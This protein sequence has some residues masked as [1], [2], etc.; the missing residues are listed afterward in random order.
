M[1]LHEQSMLHRQPK[2]IL[3]DLINVIEKVRLAC[4]P[5]PEKWE[6]AR[7][8]AMELCKETIHYVKYQTESREQALKLFFAIEQALNFCRNVKDL[9][10]RGQE[11]ADP[12][13]A[14]FY[15]RLAKFTGADYHRAAA[16]AAAR[17]IVCLSQF[18]AEINLVPSVAGCQIVKEMHHQGDVASTSNRFAASSSVNHSLS[19]IGEILLSLRES[20]NQNEW[21]VAEN[22]ANQLFQTVSQMKN[23]PENEGEAQAHK[24]DRWNEWFEWIQHLIDAIQKASTLFQTVNHSLVHEDENKR[25]HKNRLQ[26]QECVAMRLRYIVTYFRRGALADTRDRKSTEEISIKA[27]ALAMFYLEGLYGY[28]RLVQVEQRNQGDIFHVYDLTEAQKM[29]LNEQ[30]S[31]LTCFV[32]QAEELAQA[33]VTALNTPQQG[34]T[35]KSQSDKHCVKLFDLIL[36]HI[37]PNTKKLAKDIKDITNRIR[38]PSG[39]KTSP[40]QEAKIHVWAN[41][42]DLIEEIQSK[43]SRSLLGEV[44]RINECITSNPNHSSDPLSS[45]ALQI[46]DLIKNLSE[47][48]SKHLAPMVQEAMKKIE[49]ILQNNDTS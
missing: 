10:K 39:E 25:S 8:Y 29:K 28:I 34:D 17:V 33:L 27:K 6:V 11:E 23:K 12:L 24:W 31:G 41:I 2:E 38:Q 42:K 18:P 1:S 30:I 9:T 36:D 43:V 44:T 37:H 15:K 21:E 49:P 14:C 45:I 20:M 19:R 7:D 16:E 48:M 5:D 46:Q 35:V 47:K 26:L 4:I 13:K 3:Q 22:K 32:I 40:E